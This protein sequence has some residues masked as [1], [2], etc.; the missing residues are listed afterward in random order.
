[1]D[2]NSGSLIRKESV[3]PGQNRM[4]PAWKAVWIDVDQ[5]LLDFDLCA[6][7][8]LHQAFLEMN[9]PW[10]KDTFERFTLLNDTLW[11]L[12]EQERMTYEILKKIRFT[13]IFR[14]LGIEPGKD[15]DPDLM[16]ARFHDLLH[17][18][19]IPVKGALEAVN[20]LSG[21]MPLFIAT[22]GPQERQASRLEQAGF[23]GVFQEVLASD[24]LKASKPNAVF[25]QNALEETRR[26]LKI[27][28]LQFSQI[29]MIGDS[30]QADIMAA[31]KLGMQSIWFCKDGFN[32]TD[33]RN[34]AASEKDGRKIRTAFSW[35]E[36]MEQIAG[37]DIDRKTE[38]MLSPAHS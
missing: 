22:N 29:L 35:S 38:N 2:K 32:D 5:T 28:D 16:E 8:C 18:C 23:H 17:D 12:I 36:V 25:F 14:E 1:M 7:V 37:E 3:R 10:K 24:V 26:K 4:K 21:Q 9:L 33:R 6:E 20:V 27:P 15:A 30:F 11:D 19:G 13:L 31:E 34:L